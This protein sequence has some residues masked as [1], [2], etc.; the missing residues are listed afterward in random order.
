MTT[1]PKPAGHWTHGFA[2]EPY[3]H[4]QP[5][6][7]YRVAAEFTDYDGDVHPAGES[8]TYLSKN[9]LPYDGG[10]SLFVSLDGM[11][12]WHIR[13]QDQDQAEILHHLDSYIAAV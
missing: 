12:E 7:A 3:R 2:G 9:Y 4:L 13:M 8:W 10:L 1:G 6:H 5:G 11:Q